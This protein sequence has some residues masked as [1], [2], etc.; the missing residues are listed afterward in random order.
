MPLPV[1]VAL[2]INP[3]AESSLSENLLVNFTLLAQLDLGF[4]NVD[5]SRQVSR[6]TILELFFPRKGFTHGIF[7]S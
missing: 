5:F 4:K 2:S 1:I 3:P 7:S 6:H